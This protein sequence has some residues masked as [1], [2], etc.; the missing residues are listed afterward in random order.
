MRVRL[1]RK[2]SN[3]LNGID[4]SRYQQGDTLDLPARDADML[5]AEGWAERTEDPTRDRAADQPARRRTRRK[6]KKRR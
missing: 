6:S 1:T 2:F 3:L 5:V 4:L